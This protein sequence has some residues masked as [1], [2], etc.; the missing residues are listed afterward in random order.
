MTDSTFQETV[1]DQIEHAPY[2]LVSIAFHFM[3]GL[4]LA[5]MAFLRVQESEAPIIEMIA[6]PPPP[7][8]EEDEIPPE[9]EE[10]VEPVMEPTL[11]ESPLQEVTEPTE[12][13]GDPDFQS[14]NAPFDATAFSNVAGIGGPPGGL[15]GQ[16]GGPSS[17]G[18]SAPTEVAVGKALRWLADHQ[19]PDGSWDSDGFM[20]FDRLADQP[21]CDGAGSP[22]NDV[23]LTGLSLLAFLGHGD[24][25]SQGKYRENVRAGITFLRQVQNDSGLYGEEVGNATLYNHSIATLAMAEACHLGGNSPI[26]KRSLKKGVGVILRA[27]NPYGAWRYSLEPNGDNDTSITGWM[28]FALKAAEGAG[29]AIDHAVFRDAD[30]WLTS[31]TDPTNGRTGYAFGEGGGPGSRPSRPRHEV[32]RFPAEHSEALTAVALLSREFMTDTSKVKRWKDHPQYAS[33]AKQAD[34]IASKVPL[35]D[36]EGGHCDFYYWYYATFAMNQWGGRHWTSWKKAMEKALLPHQRTDGNFE[37]SWDPIGPW[38]K[39][40][41]RVYSTAMGALMLEVYYRYAKV[42][43]AR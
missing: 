14:D 23:G 36:E 18:G 29:V 39:D 21:S 5:G 12:I 37:G 11:V 34:L 4:I 25:T 15:Y 41:G 30:A 1:A 31:M 19:A 13:T 16:R 28:V 43:G 17:G 8:V 10:I 27:R 2:L 20:D 22:V 32:E 40:G 9:P 38:G 26:L 35:W 7:M 33:L 6:T 24:T 3:V 42:L